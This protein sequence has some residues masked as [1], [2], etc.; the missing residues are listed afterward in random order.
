MSTMTCDR[1]DCDNIMCPRYSFIYGYLCDECFEE[2]VSLGPETN[3]ALFMDSSAQIHA[4]K[5]E[6]A[7]EKFGAE[8]QNVGLR[9]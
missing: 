3:I 5:E 4:N 8:F 1:R 2:L 7:R 6:D 9:T